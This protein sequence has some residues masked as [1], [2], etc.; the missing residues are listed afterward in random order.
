MVVPVG[1]VE[2]VEEPVAP[3]GPVVE[4]VGFVEPVEEP[5]ELVVPADPLVCVAPVVAP[6]EVCVTVAIL[7]YPESFMVN[8]LPLCEKVEVG[9]EVGPEVAVL[10]SMKEV[11]ESE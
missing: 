8:V 9:R 7:G 10:I 1:F 2:P 11:P 6:P 3:V 5:A 4:P